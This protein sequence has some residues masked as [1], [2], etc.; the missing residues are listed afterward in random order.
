MQ[1]DRSHIKALQDQ[2]CI[3]IAFVK[4]NY[5]KRHAAG[6]NRKLEWQTVHQIAL[7]QGEKW[8]VETESGS[9]KNRFRNS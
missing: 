1:S 5:E 9:S 4:T 3:G 8:C 6:R 2:R 7:T